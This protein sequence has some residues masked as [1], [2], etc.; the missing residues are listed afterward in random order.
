V[1]AASIVSFKTPM[2]RRTEAML[3][4]SAGDALRTPSTWHLL[5]TANFADTV[6][7]LARPEK[8]GSVANR[9]ARRAARTVRHSWGKKVKEYD[10]HFPHANLVTGLALNLGLARVGAHERHEVVH[11]LKET[12]LGVSLLMAATSI[13]SGVRVQ[14][15]R[16]A[17]ELVHEDRAVVKP[18]VASSRATARLDERRQ[19]AQR[20]HD[21]IPKVVGAAPVAAALTQVPLFSFGNARVARQ[22]MDSLK[23]LSDALFGQLAGLTPHQ[24]VDLVQSLGNRKI[25]KMLDRAL[26]QRSGKGPVSR[27]EAQELANEYVR[28]VAVGMLSGTMDT[29]QAA[30]GDVGPSVVGAYQSF[31]MG[32][33]VKTGMGNLTYTMAMGLNETRHLAHRLGVE[34]ST[35]FNRESLGQVRRMV[36]ES[37]QNYGAYVIGL[38]RAVKARG[39]KGRA[40]RLVQKGAQRRTD[41][42]GVY[43][44]LAGQA[45]GDAEKIWRMASGQV[46]HHVGRMLRRGGPEPAP[47]L[48][49]SGG[50]RDALR[51]VNTRLRTGQK[52]ASRGPLGRRRQRFLGELSELQDSIVELAASSGTSAVE[53]GATGPLRHALEGAKELVRKHPNVFR[54]D[55]WEHALGPE[56]AETAWVVTAQGIHM[57]GLT[58][59]GERAYKPFE[60]ARG[61]TKEVGLVMSGALHTA[62]SGFADNWAGQLVH[63]KQLTKTF[64]SQLANTWVH[65]PSEALGIDSLQSSP[66]Q[67]HDLTVALERE[68][69]R[70]HAPAAEL[71][72]MYDDVYKHFLLTK[73]MS[74]NWAVFGGGESLIGNSPHFSAVS[75]DLKQAVDLRATLRD[76]PKYA[77]QHAQR[78]GLTH[79]QAR[80][81]GVLLERNLLSGRNPFRP[82]NRA[83]HSPPRK[84]SGQGH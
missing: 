48:A 80:Y 72:D 29:T 75:N 40:A 61:R 78:F 14:A 24:A 21:A 52:L 65:K 6:S 42:E 25:P 46:E 34:Q 56:L 83:R 3:G 31:G 10:R 28:D 36:R 57:V 12:A 59:V 49:E 76:I 73:Y 33:M 66:G 44:E 63:T 53:D 13:G 55:Y 54:F 9:L 2:L 74:I 81:F 60:R 51:G 4:R 20:L 30:F 17:D 82:E 58:P 69:K 45:R 37:W 23:K 5:L 1:G 7:A 26:K 16:F 43:F 62:L 15:K 19:H 35:L 11:G 47:E 79:L 64:I 32:E 70:Q 84:S 18:A 71:R 38:D 8:N 77:R 41:G 22:K 50:E 39:A 67:F 68:M 27:E